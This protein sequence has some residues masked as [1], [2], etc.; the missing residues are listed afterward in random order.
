MSRGRKNLLDEAVGLGQAVDLP[1]GRVHGPVH[2]P[3]VAAVGGL[4]GEQDPQTSVGIRQ[5]M[6]EIDVGD[7]VL[8]K[9]IVELTSPLTAFAK[10]LTLAL[11]G[12]DL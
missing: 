2:R 4:S 1:L 9:K 11:D 5:R 7:A 6:R 10:S 3:V 8:R 12:F